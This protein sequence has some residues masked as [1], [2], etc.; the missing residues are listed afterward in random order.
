MGLRTLATTPFSRLSAWLDETGRFDYPK[1]ETEKADRQAQTDAWKARQASKVM[2]MF[3]IWC[4]TAIQWIMM[5][6][7][8]PTSYE[9]EPGET[10]WSGWALLIAATATV[11]GSVVYCL[12]LRPRKLRFVPYYALIIVGAGIFVPQRLSTWNFSSFWLALAV[13]VGGWYSYWYFL[14]ASVESR[15][16][17]PMWRR[18]Q[19][20]DNPQ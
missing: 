14:R 5:V 9:L 2:A 4:C 15:D 13:V 10:Q 11:L 18:P 12:L 7:Y 3:L 17:Y 20:P 1:T 16:R 19:T 8:L 6:I